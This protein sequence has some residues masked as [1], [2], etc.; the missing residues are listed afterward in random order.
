MAE[1]NGAFGEKMLGISSI[2]RILFEAEA[3]GKGPRRLSKAG[4]G[5][6][7]C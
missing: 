6:D 4:F 1:R 5:L 3:S 2:I 7:G